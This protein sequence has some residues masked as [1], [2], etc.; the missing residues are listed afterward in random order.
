MLYETHEAEGNCVLVVLRDTDR[1]FHLEKHILVPRVH[2]DDWNNLDTAVD[3]R[4]RSATARPVHPAV[5]VAHVAS[6]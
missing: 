5:D 2:G 3:L 6:N 1:I 4:V